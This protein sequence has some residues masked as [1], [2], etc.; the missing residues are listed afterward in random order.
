MNTALRKYFF[1][2]KRDYGILNMLIEKFSVKL[3]S[4]FYPTQQIKYPYSH[5]VNENNLCSFNFFQADAR[6][7]L[8][9]IK[10]PA[11]FLCASRPKQR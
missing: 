4:A 11:L 8:S 7:R 6:K 5:R 10:T 2:V 1:C 3:S 9:V